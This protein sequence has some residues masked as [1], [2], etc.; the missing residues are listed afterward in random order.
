MVK[1]QRLM[2]IEREEISRQLASGFSIHKIAESLNRA[3]STISR[4]VNRS[5]VDHKYCRAIFAQQHSNKIRRKLKTRKLD[6]NIT[7]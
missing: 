2:L 7:L 6:T 4:E 5:V 3:T 1:Y